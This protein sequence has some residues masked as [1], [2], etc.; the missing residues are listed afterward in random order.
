L[1]GDFDD[2]NRM[3]VVMRIVLPEELATVP[4][5]DRNGGYFRELVQRLP[6]PKEGTCIRYF[7]FESTENAM[8]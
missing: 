4:F 5:A 8:G 1:E 3:I 7:E 2:R 6:N